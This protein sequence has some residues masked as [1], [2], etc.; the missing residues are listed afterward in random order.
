[1]PIKM[2][3]NVYR[4]DNILQK[5]FQEDGFGIGKWLPGMG[6]AGQITKKFDPS[7]WNKI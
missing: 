2:C 5:H 3:R 7:F 1:M 4:N 6:I